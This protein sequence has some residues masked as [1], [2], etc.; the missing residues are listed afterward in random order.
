SR[1]QHRVYFVL[2]LADSYNNVHILTRRKE[3]GEN[4]EQTSYHKPGDIPP[5]QKPWEFSPAVEVV[6]QPQVV[7]VQPV[8]SQCTNSKE[9]STKRRRPKKY[10]PILRSYPKIAPHPGDTSGC[11]GRG[12]SC[13]SS[14]S[15]GSE[16]GSGLASSHRERHHI[17][18]GKQ[19]RHQ[20]G[21]SGSSGSSTPGLAPHSSSLSPSPQLRLS[22]TPSLSL[23]DSSACSSPARPSPAVSRSEFTPAPSPALTLTPSQS[24]TSE[25]TKKPQALPQ[26]TATDDDK[27]RDDGNRGGGGGGVGDDVKRKRF[28]NTYNI[29]SKSGLL[30]ITLRTK[31]L[32]RQN[33][34]TQGELDRLKEQ[35]SL[36]LQALKTGDTSVW[37]K[38]QASLQEEKEK[39]GGWQNSLTPDAD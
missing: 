31:D 8:V 15:S 7:F 1:V 4:W 21:S 38:L 34:R 3:T 9:A 30:D 19:Q 35:T 36:F 32:L 33:R 10:I 20:S 29:L 24:L 26:P 16:R 12:T 2:G 17:H 23:T 13:S 11:S 37:S 25:P 27:S 5:S 18:R 28:C 39:G 6:Q 14:S 22:L